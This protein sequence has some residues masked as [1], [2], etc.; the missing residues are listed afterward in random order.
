M[1]YELIT[2]RE[3]RANQKR[4]LDIADDGKS[5]FIK[6]RGGRYYRLAVPTRLPEFATKPILCE[7]KRESGE[8][9]VMWCKHN[10]NNIAKSAGN[11]DG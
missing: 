7:H 6:R 5:I 9:P 3:F 8:C 2:A 11:S 1:E 10:P 4:Y